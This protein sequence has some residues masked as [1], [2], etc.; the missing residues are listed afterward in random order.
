MSEF[1]NIASIL[2]N[3][4]KLVINGIMHSLCEIEIYLHGE[5]HED[6]YAHRHPDQ[7]KQG[8][9]HF[10]RSSNKTGAK[11]KGGTY[12]GVDLTYASKDLYCGI[13]VIKVFP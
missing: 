8:N 9:F 10:H 3:S 6:L 2:L 4:R 13:L 1:Q 5:E 11:Y 12:K 7:L